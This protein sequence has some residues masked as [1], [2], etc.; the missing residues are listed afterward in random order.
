MSDLTPAPDFADP[1]ESSEPEVSADET[2]AELG[3]DGQQV[4]EAVAGPEAKTYEFDFGD[5]PVQATAQE[6]NDWRTDASNMRAMQAASTQRY[7]D[8]K[9][10]NDDFEAKQNDPEF[11]RLKNIDLMLREHPE[12]L[13]EFQRLAQHLEN[14]RQP[15]PGQQPINTHL[16]YQNTILRNKAEA[17]E[18]AQ[19]ETE[20]LGQVGAFR[21]K[22][23]EVSDEQFG[24]MYEAMKAEVAPEVMNSP[25]FGAVL[26]FYHYQHYG[27]A[28]TQAKVAD[29][30]KD[31]M[32]EAQKK[33][34]AGKSIGGV[35]PAG[36][37]PQTWSPPDNAPGGLQ[38]S[39][40]AALKDPT[41]QFD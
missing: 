5:G 40:E 20:V 37:D 19:R 8:A 30:R 18:R 16:A 6:I 17:L 11:Q 3:E 34:M 15:Y 7:Q 21:D 14:P 23:P 38:A 2:T 39:Y 24:A 35:A 13:A 10:L 22:H 12:T 1:S 33:I 25:N 27:A 29:A 4:Q 28:E 36:H 32:S 31:G 41:I 9:K 26:D